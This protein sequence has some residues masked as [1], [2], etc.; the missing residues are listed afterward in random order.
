MH[1]ASLHL[2]RRQPPPH[3]QVMLPTSIQ[4]RT[5]PHSRPSSHH[6]ILQY[7]TSSRTTS[8]PGRQQP[9]AKPE[10][11]DGEHRGDPRVTAGY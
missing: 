7:A 11:P 4:T 6:S 1:A 9:C 5:R 10:N 3:A 8:S 2:R